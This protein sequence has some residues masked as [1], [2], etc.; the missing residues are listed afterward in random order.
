MYNIKNDIG[1]I[2]QMI[3]TFKEVSS[4]T[5]KWKELGLTEDD[6]VVLEELLLK[7]TK[8]GDVIQGTGGLRKIRIPMENIGKRSGARVIYIDI[9]IKECIYLLDVYAKNEKID[10]SEKEKAMLKKLVN[11]LK[12]E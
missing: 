1:V 4:F 2:I 6:L 12:E 8:I 5:K 10:L 9:E 7:D 11:A 3:R